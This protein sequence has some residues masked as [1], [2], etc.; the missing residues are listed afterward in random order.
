MPNAACS[1]DPLATL[2]AAACGA[3]SA[4]TRC[5]CQH[6]H[7]S[8]PHDRTA[9]REGAQ[10]QLECI[11]VAH[12]HTH[13][14]SLSGSSVACNAP[15]DDRWLVCYSPVNSF[16]PET[17]ELSIHSFILDSPSCSCRSFNFVITIPFWPIPP[18]PPPACLLLLRWDLP[19]HVPSGIKL[20][21]AYF[22]AYQFFFI[23]CNDF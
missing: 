6:P 20:V 13:T 15:K 12:S 4:R 10:W 5:Q 18:P 22:S 21:F 16:M 7:P 11:M 23:C 1:S 9:G 3:A 14:H 8:L 17:R 19:G 2:G